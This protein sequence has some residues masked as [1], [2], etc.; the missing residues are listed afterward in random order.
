M[1][2]RLGGCAR[3]ALLASL[4]G[5][6]LTTPPPSEVSDAIDAAT[7]D[8]DA[9]PG[10]CTSG[11][12]IAG[13]AFN[14]SPVNLA[15]ACQIESVEE[16]D[17]EVAGLD[18]FGDLA[19]SCSTWGDEQVGG[20]GCVGLDLGA[21][22]PVGAFTVRAQPVADACGNACTVDC[23]TG[24]TFSAWTGLVAGEYAA[25]ANV[26]M[27]SDS[28]TDYTVEVGDAV[29]YVVVCRDKWDVTRDDVAVDSITVLCR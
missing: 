3:V 2:T 23:G 12:R 6:C 20:C 1:G 15:N 29:R 28:L 8:R 18:R 10:A 27:T 13:T 22:Y 17:G 5:G 25:A 4:C 7:A 24:D 14:A 16:E 19:T 21:A 26:T 11:E 9:S